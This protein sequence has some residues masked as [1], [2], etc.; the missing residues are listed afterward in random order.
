MKYYVYLVYS[1]TNLHDTHREYVAENNANAFEES[2]KQNK[3]YSF[4][5]LFETI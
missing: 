2:F 4:K 3:G 5:K 1:L